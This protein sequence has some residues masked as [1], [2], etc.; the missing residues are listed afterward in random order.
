VAQTVSDIMTR[1]V[2]QLPAET[3]LVDAA[4][5]M[6]DRQIGNV[7]VTDHG[8]LRGLTT[9]RDIV[10]RAVAESKHPAHTRLAE[11]VSGDVVRISQDATPAEAADVM[12]REAVRRLV[13]TDHTGSVTGIVSLGDLAIANDPTSALGV[14]SG[15]PGNE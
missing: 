2:V 4:R 8:T 14:I 7:L 15:A 12:R 5:A 6:R 11:I 3:N 9:D 1:V 10:V 13:V